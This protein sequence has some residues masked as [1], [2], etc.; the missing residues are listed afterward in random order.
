MLNR[1]NYK[2]FQMEWIILNTVNCFLGFLLWLILGVLIDN[3][4][5]K[6]NLAFYLIL[7]VLPGVVIGLSQW[8]L[9]LK[10]IPTI[11]WL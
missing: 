11:S 7:F 9:L 5:L 1:Q 10:K 3:I 8:L 2:N 6:P 4:Q